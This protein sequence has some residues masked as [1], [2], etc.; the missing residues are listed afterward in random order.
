[1]KSK[2]A[3]IFAIVFVA[4]GIANAR[5][6]AIPSAGTEKEIITGG[7]HTDAVPFATI[8]AAIVNTQGYANLKIFA[9][10]TGAK[11][12][13]DIFPEYTDDTAWFSGS[14]IEIT[15]DTAAS[16]STFATDAMAI[17]INNR[18]GGNSITIKVTPYNE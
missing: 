13:F 15:Q 4:A 17:R 1:M 12:I 2:I 8:D 14:S 16:V 9:D 7:I 5:P 6:P 18:A 11:P 3:V 10:V